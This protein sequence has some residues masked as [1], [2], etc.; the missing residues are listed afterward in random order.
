MQDCRV[1]GLRI[2]LVD[3][4]CAI[5]TVAAAN[6]FAAHP[7]SLRESIFRIDVVAA[8]RGQ[9]AMRAVEGQQQTTHR[10]LAEQEFHRCVRIPQCRRVRQI[11][12]SGGRSNMCCSS[13]DCIART[14]RMT[15]GSTFQVTSPQTTPSWMTAGHRS[16]VVCAKAVG[17]GASALSSAPKVA[18]TMTLANQHPFFTSAVT[19][20]S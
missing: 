3:R 10:G 20:A 19:D 7:K 9:R 8:V 12:F 17:G 14:W 15:N 2:G 4:E 13:P 6:R 1:T 5:D 16:G 11:E 18:R